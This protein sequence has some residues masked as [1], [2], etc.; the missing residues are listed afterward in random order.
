MTGGELEGAV[1]VRGDGFGVEVGD[2]T[3]GDD[4]TGQHD[5]AAYPDDVPAGHSKQAVDPV[6]SEYS[7]QPQL[8]HD[9]PTVGFL[10]PAEQSVH[11]VAAYPD[12]VPTGHGVHASLFRQYP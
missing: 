2:G 12:D 4:G 1:E 7:P 8:E 10:Y 11:D 5:V 6:L 9:D 3:D